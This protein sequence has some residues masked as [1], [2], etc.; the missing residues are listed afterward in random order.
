MTTII[1]TADGMWADSRMTVA[2]TMTTV[3]KVFR[4][5]GHLVGIAGDSRFTDE[6]LKK[7]R[8]SSSLQAPET[9]A[10]D[11]ESFW[12]LVVTPAGQIW[13]FDEHFSKDLL[14]DPYFAIGTGASF[15]LTAMDLGLEPEDAIQVA[16][17][18]DPGTDDQI[19]HYKLRDA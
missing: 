4:V 5:R 15:A 12:A 7:F 19:Q 3:Q 10:T 6:F 11:K 1:A 17:W 13:L 8:K 9:P 14:R 18:R 2:D 16:S